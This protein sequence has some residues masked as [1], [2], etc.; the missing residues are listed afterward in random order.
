VA[1]RDDVDWRRMDLIVD[2][3]LANPP[4]IHGF[5]EDPRLYSLQHHALRFIERTAR[6][7]DRTLETGSGYSTIVFAASGAAHTC[8][9][10]NEDQVRRITEY[11]E[12]N[13]VS[14]DAVS[15]ELDRSENVLPHLERSPLHLVLLDGSHS[16][17]Q[18]FIDWFFTAD[19]LVVGGH[20][21]VDDIHIWTGRVLCDFLKKEPG[22]RLTTTLRG[23]TAVFM[24]EAGGDVGRQWT[25]QPYVAARTRRA[26]VA[27]AVIVGEM[28]RRGE[29]SEVRR[30]VRRLLQGH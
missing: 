30:A 3:L 1:A 17:P 28:L 18:V 10:P 20:L 4:P 13:G 7:G 5:A 8:V 25:S 14:L 19:R 6:P 9:V 2:R 23:R 26:V 27:K 24:K 12:S 21:L 15:F 29:I 11:C 22:W 16:F